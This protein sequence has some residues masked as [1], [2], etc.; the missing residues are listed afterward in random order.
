L[1][2]HHQGDYLGAIV[3]FD[4]AI[5]ID[6]Q[7]AL[8]Y[9]NLGAVFIDLGDYDQAIVDCTKA[10]ELEPGYAVAYHNRGRA[11][12]KI[13]DH[14]QAIAD[15]GKALELGLE[16]DRVQEAEALLEDLAGKQ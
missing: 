11:Y 15:L 8:A 9:N 6:P 3:D 13:G 10:I 4:G 14:E 5:D 2:Y 12:H 1:V 16:L 7:F